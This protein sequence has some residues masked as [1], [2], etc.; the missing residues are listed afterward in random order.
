[1]KNNIPQKTRKIIDEI[2]ECMDSDFVMSAGRGYKMLPDGNWVENKRIE[3]G[4]GR[5]LH[6]ID[7]DRSNN[8]YWN[9]IPL[10][11]DE[12]IIILHGLHGVRQH[13]QSER[14]R[15]TCKTIFESIYEKLETIRQIM[16]NEG[17]SRDFPCERELELFY[18]R[19]LYINEI[20]KFE[21]IT[22]GRW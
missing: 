7:L 16:A 18:R 5:D 11:H 21:Q 10:Q 20:E 17:R 13:L 4:Y 22:I 8:E 1:M 6:H 15:N 9:L 2:W 3:K 19:H 12:H 14:F